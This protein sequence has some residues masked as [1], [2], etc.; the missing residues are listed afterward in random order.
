MA[1]IDINTI[2]IH[3]SPDV[4]GW[5]QT[6][7]ISKVVFDNHGV[8][9]DFDKHQAWPDVTPPGWTGPVQYT[10]W[11]FIYRNNEW[12]GAG[13]VEMWRDRGS[14]G[15]YTQPTLAQHFTENWIHDDGWD[16]IP[17]ISTGEPVG[18]MVTAGDARKK[19]VHLVAERSNIVVVPVA[20]SAV[21]TF[22]SPIP[23]PEPPPDPDPTPVPELIAL[24]KSIDE[25][26]TT[27]LAKPPVTYVGKIPYFGTITLLPK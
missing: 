7:T 13:I 22:D 19:D 8:A 24:L 10:V 23:P 25:K 15:D 1:T 14:T 26:L 5:S 2:Q 4:R 3:N 20:N 17:A 21:Y 16:A 27:L 18:I 9:V 6:A 12:H 11:L